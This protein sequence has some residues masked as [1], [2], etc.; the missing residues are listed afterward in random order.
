M[1]FVYFRTPTNDAW[2]SD[3]DKNG[4]IWNGMQGVVNAL[5]D[6]NMGYPVYYS[7]FNRYLPD[8]HGEF[9]GYITKRSRATSDPVNLPTVLDT[10]L[11]DITNGVTKQI[12][13]YGH[14][15]N[16]WMVNYNVSAFIWA[17]EVG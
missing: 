3:F 4:A 2:A 16:G 5:I 6:P 9:P 8:P 14:G 1:D 7:Y 12:Y 17:G 10:L 13:I 11:P 15:D